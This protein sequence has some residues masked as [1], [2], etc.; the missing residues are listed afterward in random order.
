MKLKHLF[1]K[2]VKSLKLYHILDHFD[3]PEFKVQAFNRSRN[4]NYSYRMYNNHKA[5]LETSLT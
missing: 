2:R 1:G 5:G 4:H 3:S